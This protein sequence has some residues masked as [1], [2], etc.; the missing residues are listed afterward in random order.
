M[1]LKP[2]EPTELTDWTQH[3]SS[4]LLPSPVTNVWRLDLEAL[5]IYLQ[6][7]GDCFHSSVSCCRQSYFTFCSLLKEKKKLH[8]DKSCHAPANLG[9]DLRAV[10]TG[11]HWH[12]VTKHM[13]KVKGRT[14]V[15]MPSCGTFSPLSSL[16]LRTNVVFFSLLLLLVKLQGDGRQGNKE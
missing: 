4:S 7:S 14:R 9:A 15:L 16:I 6:V 1:N 5:P 8:S 2:T 10:C 12:Q 11:W 3:S 13:R